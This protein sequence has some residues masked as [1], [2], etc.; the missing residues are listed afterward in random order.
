[1]FVFV[2]ILLILLGALMVWFNIS[3]SPVKK[4]FDK[5]IKRIMS[6]NKLETGNEVFTEEDFADTPYAIRQYIKNSGYIG[7]PKMSYTKISF[8]DV[9][10]MQSKKGPALSID[11]TQY[12]FAGEPCRMAL[13]ESSMFGI[14]FEGCDYYENG[15]GGMKGVIAK[16]FTIF[17]QNGEDMDSAGLVTYLSEIL[18]V[19]SA[20]LE[21]DVS[22]S[23]VDEYTVDAQITFDGK[24][25]NGRFFFNEEY[26]L[27]RFTTDERAMASTDGK[28]EYVPWTACCSEYEVGESGIKYPKKLKA[29]WNLEEGDLVYFEGEI[30]DI[31]YGY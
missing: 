15:K 30:S 9:D 16:L 3:Y 26:E 24:T 23:E 14:P 8:R 11:Y 28:I 7:K 20:I 13:I 31:S 27:I 21:N 25:V 10:F 18:F 1:M 22:F 4:T 17:D 2:G 19:P 5:D 12:D 29:V 6:E